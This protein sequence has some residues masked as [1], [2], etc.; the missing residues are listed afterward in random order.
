MNESV[1]DGWVETTLEEVGTWCSGG[2][3]SRTQ[4]Q[5]FGGSIPWVKSGDLPDG[6]VVTT[7][8]TISEEGLVNSAAKIL[9][10]GTISMAMYGATI[11]KLGILTEQAATNQA[12]ANVVPNPEIIET[13]YLFYYLL[14]QR[15]QFVNKGQGG[16]QPNIS[17]QIVRAHN[18]WIA[19]LSEQRRIATKLDELLGKIN[20]CQKRLA[21][22][23]T[24][25]G[26]LDIADQKGLGVQAWVGSLTQSI[27]AKAFRGELVP[28]EPNDSPVEID[29]AG[30]VAA[31]P[32]DSEPSGLQHPRIHRKTLKN[33][34]ELMRS[35][36]ERS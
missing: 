14:S 30:V 5:Y 13:R 1:P 21:R 35:R 29:Q 23:S 34:R 15:R 22:I 31:P 20:D 32:E 3:P 16:A 7:E 8:E 33:Q 19:P 9:P 27:L 17:Q 4:R 6:P 11:G 24:L 36:H 10:P 26:L 2:T 18:I 12:C 25:L 28:Q